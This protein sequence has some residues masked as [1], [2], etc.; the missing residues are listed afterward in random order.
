MDI[1]QDPE[2]RE[3][4]VFYEKDY[5]SHLPLWRLTTNFCERSKLKSRTLIL[6]LKFTV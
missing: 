3:C 5:E 1:P 2:V 4:E 6:F